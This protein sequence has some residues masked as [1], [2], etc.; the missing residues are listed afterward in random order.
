ML[1]AAESFFEWAVKRAAVMIAQAACDQHDR[2][3]RRGGHHQTAEG[4]DPS[5]TATASTKH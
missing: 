5:D 4:I 1:K 2:E 3:V